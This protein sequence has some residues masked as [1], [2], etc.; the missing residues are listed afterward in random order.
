MNSSTHARKAPI[1][2]LLLAIAFLFTVS[3]SWAVTW[4]F[5]PTASASPDATSPATADTLFNIWTYPIAANDAIEL[6]S[7][8]YGL[9]G[10]ILNVNIP[11]HI[12]GAG[13]GATVLL[14]GNPTIRFQAGSTGSTLSNLSVVQSLSDGIVMNNAEV[15]IQYVD[16]DQCAANGINANGPGSTGGLS[17][18]GLFNNQTG[19]YSNASSLS[20]IN[21]SRI[22]NNTAWG[23]YYNLNGI[24]RIEKSEFRNNGIG[25]EIQGTGN[26]VETV[27]SLFVQNGSGIMITNGGAAGGNKILDN[28]FRRTA[29]V[30]IGIAA[31]NDQ[32]EVNANLFWRD[33][34]AISL[35]QFTN[36]TV[37]NN[38]IRNTI[39][40]AIYTTQAGAD[41]H[42][43]T[44][45]WAW[46]GINT[47]GADT[48]RLDNN[49]VYQCT[50][51]G[52]LSGTLPIN[53]NCNDSWGNTPNY[54]GTGGFAGVGNVAV[55]PMFTF[56]P[57]Y[58]SIDPASPIWNGACNTA[59]GFDHYG[60][61]RDPMGF[62]EPGAVEN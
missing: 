14:N 11:V 57:R 54:G 40:T 58:F 21:N 22:N 38:I 44:I 28:T 59:I 18:V 24:T 15:H 42:Y 3:P 49:I 55:D 8:V 33:G 46:E 31:P 30:A 13:T 10:W 6:A 41:I 12:T 43:N 39:G 62:A 7:G 36:T 52:I 35:G 2:N 51:G 26:A 47:N 50:A 27:E 60:A 53:A 9:G 25:M 16:V 32:T 5:A 34:M 45:A 48:S 4:Y 1:R 17:F 19:L 23:I 37:T 20:Y 29:N 56:G 61:A